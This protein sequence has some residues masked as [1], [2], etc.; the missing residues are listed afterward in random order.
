MPAGNAKKSLYGV[1]TGKIVLTLKAWLDGNPSAKKERH[2]GKN[3][4][5]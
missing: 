1:D 5:Q 4:G 2:A 3:D